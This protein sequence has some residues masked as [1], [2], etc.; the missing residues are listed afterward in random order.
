VE[1]VAPDEA[2]LALEI[3]R[4]ERHAADN[5]SLETRRVGIDRVDDEIGG[6]FAMIVPG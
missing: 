4:R 2:E 5:R 1:D 6:R 3:E